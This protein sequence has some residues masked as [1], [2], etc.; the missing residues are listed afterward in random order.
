MMNLK[1]LKSTCVM[2]KIIIGGGL[3]TEAMGL[4]NEDFL[5]DDQRECMFS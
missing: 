2:K 3:Y 5:D 1:K 4:E